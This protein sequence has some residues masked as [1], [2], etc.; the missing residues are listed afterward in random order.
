MKEPFQGHVRVRKVSIRTGAK[1]NLEEKC[2]TLY[3]R[4]KKYHFISMLPG[5]LA[6]PCVKGS[7]EVKK[8]GW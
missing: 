4:Q 3:S 8:F 7:M 6:R 2:V 5:S 1:R